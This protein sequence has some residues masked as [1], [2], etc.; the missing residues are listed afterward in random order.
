MEAIV[1]AP[2]IARRLLLVA[3]ALACVLPATSVAGGRR[4]STASLETYAG[5]GSWLDIFAKPTWSHPDAVIASLKAHAARTLYLQT[6][7]YSQP[8]DIV[9]PAATG[10]FLDAAHAAGLRVVAWYLPSFASPALDARRALAAI[11]FRSVSGQRF[12]SFAL[13]IEASLVRPVS[14]RNR[15]LLSLA[16]TI[17]A[18]APTGYPL[19]AIIPSPVGMQRHP[20]YWPGFPYAQLAQVFGAFLPMAYFSYYVHRSADV[21]DYVRRVVIAIRTQTGRSDLTIHVIGGLAGGV[22]R[23]AIDGFT[24][25]ISDCAVAG[26]SLY[27]Y[28]ETTTAQWALLDGIRTGTTQVSPTCTSR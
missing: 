16:R 15:R 18:G 26:Q 7:N 20:S 13:D 28:P 14:L 12:D 25:A 6:S 1:G 23:A 10:R 5:L 9:Y 27:G 24:R 19:G 4:D 21:Y 8:V 22:G 2:L 11:R 3:L 17:R